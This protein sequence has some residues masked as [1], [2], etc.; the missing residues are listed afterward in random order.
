MRIAVHAAFNEQ[1]NSNTINML[2]AARPR[3]GFI[4]SDIARFAARA[5]R[6]AFDWDTVKLS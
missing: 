3:R 4:R 1:K 5:D 6:V 2:H